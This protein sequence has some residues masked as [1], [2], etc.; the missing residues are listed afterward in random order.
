M[1]DAVPT[2]LGSLGLFVCYRYVVPT[3]LQSF[4]SGIDRYSGAICSCSKSAAHAA[5][6][7]N[8][9]DSGRSFR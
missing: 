8:F 2:G 9:S 3:G 5:D 7:R 4:G 6:K 1:D